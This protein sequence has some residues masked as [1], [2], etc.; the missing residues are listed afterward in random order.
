MRATRRWKG[1]NSCKKGFVAERRTS[2]KPATPSS[3]PSFTSVQDVCTCASRIAFSMYAFMRSRNASSP[4]VRFSD[5][6][7]AQQR[8]VQEVLVIM[9]RGEFPTSVAAVWGIELAPAHHLLAPLTWDLREYVDPGA[10]V[11]AALGVMRGGR[12][13]RVRP[14]LEALGVQTGKLGDGDAEALRLAADLVQGDESV[15]DVKGRILHA[16]CHHR[17]R[18]LLK[19]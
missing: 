1:R 17:S 16:L 19:R 4:C 11:L 10:H 12:A 15:V 6:P 2:T 8:L 14:A 3:Y 9:A 5:R 13:P 18:V 7:G